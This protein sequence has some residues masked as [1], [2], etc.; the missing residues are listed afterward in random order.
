MGSI[1]EFVSKTF[2]IS[3]KNGKNKQSKTY[4]NVCVCV[5]YSNSD[6]V[7]QKLFLNGDIYDN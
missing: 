1:F 5:G 7:S 6:L 4:V 3:F 2:Q